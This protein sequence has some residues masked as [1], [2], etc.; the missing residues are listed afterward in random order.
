MASLN[1]PPQPICKYPGCTYKRRA[2][3]IKYC[4]RCR[5]AL[6]LVKEGK[7]REGNTLMQKNLAHGKKGE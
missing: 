7:I 5:R 3:Y 1:A 2:Q 6:R 4:D